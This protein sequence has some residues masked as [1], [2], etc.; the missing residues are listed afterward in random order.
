MK[1][2]VLYFLFDAVHDIF[3][4]S[5]G[6]SFCKSNSFCSCLWGCRGTGIVVAIDVGVSGFSVDGCELVR[7]DEDIHVRKCS[8]F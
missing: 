3:H 6:C 2:K 7:V 1:S 5:R 8:I 4:Y